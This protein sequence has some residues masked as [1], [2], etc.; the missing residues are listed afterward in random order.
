MSPGLGQSFQLS[1]EDYERYRP[2]FPAAA[3]E[4]ALPRALGWALDL[5]AGTGKLTERL[6]DHAAHV[7]AVDPSEP[8]LAQLRHK[9]PQ[10][11]ALIGSAEAIPVADTSQ[12]AVTVAQAF[13]WFD[14]DAACAEVSRVLRPGGRLVLLWNHPDRDCVWDRAS[15]LIAHPAQ[16]GD[17]SAEKEVTEAPNPEQL[18]GFTAIDAFDIPWTEGLSREHYLNRWRTVSSLLAA[19]PQRATAMVG[20]I[21]AILDADPE[22]RGRDNLTVPGGTWVVVY[23]RR[24]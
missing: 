14:R 11:T 15:Y 23:T 19:T 7:T 8:M 1:G 21:E 2:G 13:H 5:G 4:R 3:L 9:L 17:G 12:D 10:A 16:E 24:S 20:E 18:P 6:V 22:T